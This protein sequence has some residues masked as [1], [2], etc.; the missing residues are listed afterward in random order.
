MNNY[1]STNESV[2]TNYSSLQVR[3][4]LERIE[5]PEPS[6]REFV[7]AKYC[8]TATLSCI[9]ICAK[10]Y[11]I[12]KLNKDTLI[13]FI[14]NTKNIYFT[15]I[16]PYE[17]GVIINIINSN[18]PTWIKARKLKRLYNRLKKKNVLYFKY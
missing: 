12:D 13:R 6:F 7:K 2:N 10:S 18:C 3:N 8:R 17:K 16:K 5:N 1:L 11:N 4:V 15:E 14:N 9:R